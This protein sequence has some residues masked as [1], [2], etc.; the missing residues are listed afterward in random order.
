MSRTGALLSLSREH[1]ASLVI[2]RAAKIVA[3]S[4][5]AVL[6]SDTV[7]RIELHWQTVLRAHFDQEE[8]LLQ[9][10]SDRLDDASITRVL[11]EHAALREFIDGLDTLRSVERLRCFGELLAAHVRY[12]ERVLFPQLQTL[13]DRTAAE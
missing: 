9:R 2:A 6:H 13:L 5:D 7:K 1:H 10:F 11:A 4:G 8:T 12:E 3:A